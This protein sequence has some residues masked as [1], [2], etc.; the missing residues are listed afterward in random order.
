MDLQRTASDHDLKI[1]T[2]LVLYKP[3]GIHGSLTAVA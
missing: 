1:A 3:A 2:M